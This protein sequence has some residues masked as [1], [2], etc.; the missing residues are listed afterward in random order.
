ML[1]VLGVPIGEQLSAALVELVALRREYLNAW[2]AQLLGVPTARYRDNFFVAWPKSTDE[3]TQG[4]PALAKQLSVLLGMPVKWEGCGKQ[5]RVLELHVDVTNKVRAVLGF[6]TDSD[7]QGESGDVTC[8]P[9]AQD[10]RARMVLGSI[11]LG[12]A[13]KIR[14]YFGTTNVGYT[15]TL[16]RVVKFLKERCYPDGWWRRQLALALM[17][18]GA[19]AACLPR[20]IRCCVVLSESK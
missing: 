6:R 20:C 10:P 18:H 11:L 4:G 13:A 7:R 9:D 12:L 2:P 16:R 5:R 8:W 1:Q 17:R 15:A 19:R 14:L 3:E